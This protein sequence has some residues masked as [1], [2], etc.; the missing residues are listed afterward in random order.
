[1][2]GSEG[3]WARA[4]ARRESSFVQVLCERS[5]CLASKRRNPPAASLDDEVVQDV[6]PPTALVAGASSRRSD[7]VLQSEQETVA[8]PTLPPPLQ[9]WLDIAG[10]LRRLLSAAAHLFQRMTAVL[11]TG[12]QGAL[13]AAVG[14]E[15]LGVP[16]PSAILEAATGLH[17]SA[18]LCDRLT[19][20]QQL[21]TPEL[22]DAFRLRLLPLVRQFVAA[23]GDWMAFCHQGENK[24][25]LAFRSA[26]LAL[27]HVAFPKMDSQ[28]LDTLALGRLLS[29][30]RELGVTLAVME[31]DNFTSLEVARGIQTHLDL[32]DRPAVA[33][34]ASRPDADALRGPEGFCPIHPTAPTTPLPATCRRRLSIQLP[35]LHHAYF[36]TVGGV[37]PGDS[38]PCSSY[39]PQHLRRDGSISSKHQPLT[40][41]VTGL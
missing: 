24:T 27:G 4:A 5:L 18:I 38:V 3:T 37:D 40:V 11:T 29:V 23:E 41:M 6:V 14:S 25:P 9:S 1:M 10:H 26:L 31:D 13:P 8:S 12:L 33:A 15:A 32:N 19:P 17:A 30:A 28:A 35:I 36:P 39:T 7:D 34:S 2:S 16:D 21:P 20:Q 22:E